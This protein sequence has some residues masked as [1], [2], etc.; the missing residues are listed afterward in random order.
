MI[1]DNSVAITGALKAIV[2]ATVPLKDYFHFVFVLPQETSAKAFIINQGFTLYTLPFMEISKNPK[3]LVFYIFYLISN[4]YKLKS[5]ATKHQ[6]AI[7][8][9]NDFYNLT[10]LMANFLGAKVKIMTHVRFLPQKFIPILA[11]LWATVNIKYA[12]QIICVSE[13]VRSYFPG[14]TKLAVI[15]DPLPENEQYASKRVNESVPQKVVHLL[16]L[17]NY[18]QGKGQDHALLAFKAA[19]KADNRLRLTF[20]GGDMGLAKNRQF[21][22]ELE[23]RASE[24]GLEKV[25]TFES[26]VPDTEK[27]I[28]AAD[29]LL[30]FSESESFSL[31]C[32]DALYYGTPLIATD[33]GGPAELFENNISGILVPNKDVEA[34]AR[35]I[36]KLAGSVPL[37]RELAENGKLYVRTKFSATN[38]YLKLKEKYCLL[39]A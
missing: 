20:A 7:I 14:T 27:A 10:G 36:I 38:G 9:T 12:H 11:K 37:Q 3:N 29:I 15:P 33:C 25:V 32:L 2:N 34:M 30:N 23:N 21:K 1:V 4:G 31:T 19:Y 35:A 13:A 24:Y 26:F 22:Q 16:Y 18:I 39:L 8:H 17:S 5:I 28:K 6:A